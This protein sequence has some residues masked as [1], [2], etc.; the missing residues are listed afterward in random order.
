VFAHRPL[1]Y[2]NSN[3]T[4]NDTVGTQDSQHTSQ[5]KDS[6]HKTVSCTLNS[7]PVGS[8]G[9]YDAGPIWIE[10]DTASSPDNHMTPIVAQFHANWVD[11]VVITHPPDNIPMVLW[12]YTW[13]N[14]GYCI[15]PAFLGWTITDSS[16][17]VSKSSTAR[18]IR[19][20]NSTGVAYH[21]EFRCTG[22]P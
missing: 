11:S 2:Y 9:N 4:P 6:L 14:S 5:V 12:P 13:S 17:S 3:H 22:G 21:A 10:L 20:G 16:G 8:G 7:A 1:G 19:P 15:S 18:L